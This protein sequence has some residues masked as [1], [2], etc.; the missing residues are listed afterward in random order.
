MAI[1]R[2]VG[3]LLGGDHPSATPRLWHNWL[4]TLRA[5]LRLERVKMRPQL[6]L[7]LVLVLRLRLRPGR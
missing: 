4:V 5:S 3:H 2:V 6:R 7:R 1:G